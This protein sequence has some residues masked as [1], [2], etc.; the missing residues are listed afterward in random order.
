MPP[1]SPA[2]EIARHPFRFALR[3]LKAFNRNQ[4]L[5]LSGAVAY[6]GLLSLIPLMGLLLIGLSHFMEPDALL[7]TVKADLVLIVPAEASALTQNVA[8]FLE[9]RHLV[10]WIGT[11]ALLF[12]STIAFTVLE[13]AMTAIF[14]HREETHSR[15]PLVSAAIPFA[16]ILL[17]GIGILLITLVNGALQAIGDNPI[18]LFGHLWDPSGAIGIA[19][20]LFS[21]MGLILLLTALYLVMPMGH[22]SFRLALIGGVTAGLLWEAVRHV[23]VWY[24]STLSLVDIIYG[25]LATAIVALLSFEV[26]ALILLLGAQVIAELERYDLEARNTQGSNSTAR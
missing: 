16:F 25:S 11:L 23:L 6:N 21:V 22:L 18:L 13:K 8:S 5:L 1:L 2:K 24:F 10:G 3:V 4:G 12:F 19:F 15:H 7:E 14:H 26:A 20:Y 9:N 17:I